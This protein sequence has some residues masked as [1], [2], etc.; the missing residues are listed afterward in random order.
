MKRIILGIALLT[1]LAGCETMQGLGRDMQK[2][3]SNLE[4]I[5]KSTT[6]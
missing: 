1:L 5:A 2:G 3:G 4:D 6:P